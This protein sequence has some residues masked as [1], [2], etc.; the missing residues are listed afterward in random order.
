MQDVADAEIDRDRIPGRADAERIDMAVGEAVHHV[1]RRQHHQPN[2]LVGIDPARRHPEPKLVV[3]GGERERHAEG[4]RFR[5][6]LAPHRDDARERQR[7]RHGIDGVALDLAHD[8]GMQRRRYRDRIAIEAKIERRHDR[9]L[10]VSEAEAGGD[11][12]R[13]QQMG[14]VEHA[15]IELVADIGPRHLPHQRHIEPF[16]GRKALVDGDDQRGGIDQRDETDMQ[17]C[18]HFNSS[19]A[20]RIDCAI[21]PIFFFSRIAVERIST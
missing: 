9:H 2:V 1:G 15:D 18:T 6:A 11:R 10:D 4:Q 21:S 13:R 3:V 19:E 16:G 17:R 14:G 12:H 8:R 7:G 20:V 5:A